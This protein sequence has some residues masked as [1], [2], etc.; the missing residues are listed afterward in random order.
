MQASP[1]KGRLSHFIGHAPRAEQTNHGPLKTALI[2]PVLERTPNGS[3]FNRL[4]V[5]CGDGGEVVLLHDPAYLP[6]EPDPPVSPAVQPVLLRR[7][8]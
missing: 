7:A 4:R 1:E 8:A 6:P 3:A 2:L 5:V